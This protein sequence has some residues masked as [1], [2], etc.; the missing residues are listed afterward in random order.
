MPDEIRAL[1]TALADD[2]DH[3]PRAHPGELRGRADRR[4]HVRATVTVVAAAVLM[5]GTAV[6]GNFLLAADHQP[7]PAHPG[8]SASVT[9]AA[10]APATPSGSPPASAPASPAATP[11]SAPASP[12]STSPSA[13]PGASTKPVPA[14]IPDRAFATVQDTLMPEHVPY[15]TSEW[16]LPTEFCTQTFPS[17]AQTGV[18]RSMYAPFRRPGTPENHGPDGGVTE[19]LTIYRG[20]GARQAFAEFRAAARDCPSNGRSTFAVDGAIPVGDESLLIRATFVGQVP[21]HNDKL[22]LTSY[23]AV[24]RVGD[25]LITMHVGV[26]ETVS[27]QRADADRLTRAAVRNLTAWR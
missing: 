13:A 11:G 16:L 9:A 8:P 6:G 26:W 1:F 3:A 21:P 24:V 12:P 27:V 14:A 25:S 4:A 7:L 2:A 22:T 10:T 23:L 15:Q 5:A 19:T 17:D 18:R 20:D